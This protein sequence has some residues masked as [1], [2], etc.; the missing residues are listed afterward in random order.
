MRVQVSLPGPRDVGTPE[1]R[2]ARQAFLDKGIPR[3]EETHGDQL[4]ALAAKMRTGS[5]GM[6]VQFSGGY[7][8]DIP[9]PLMKQL[10]DKT[11]GSHASE[12]LARSMDAPTAPQKPKPVDRT[13]APAKAHELDDVAL[14]TTT[15]LVMVGANPEKGV[16]H[17]EAP[18]QG[19]VMKGSPHATATGSSYVAKHTTCGYVASYCASQLFRVL[20]ENP[21]ASLET[22]DK[23]VKGG[24]PAAYA[25]AATKHTGDL[26][27]YGGGND[28][29]EGQ[30]ALDDI[31]NVITKSD[32]KAAPMLLLSDGNLERNS[33]A[34]IRVVSA[35]GEARAHWRVP[36]ESVQEAMTAVQSG[37][38]PFALFVMLDKMPD[39]AHYVTVAVR[40]GSDGKLETIVLDSLNTQNDQW[41]LKG[42]R[43]ETTVQWLHSHLRPAVALPAQ[44]TLG[45]E[46]FDT[47]APDNVPLLWADGVVFAPKALRDEFGTLSR[48]RESGSFPSLPSVEPPVPVEMMRLVTE[49]CAANPQAKLFAL[50]TALLGGEA[51]MK[52][53]HGKFFSDVDLTA[54]AGEIKR[55]ASLIAAAR[56]A[57][58]VEPDAVGEAGACDG[59]LVIEAFSK[60]DGV[61]DAHAFVDFM[62]RG[63]LVKIFSAS[64]PS[65]DYAAARELMTALKPPLPSNVGPLIAAAKSMASGLEME[66]AQLR[67][68]AD[69]A[70]TKSGP[71]AARQ[72]KQK[73][74][75]AAE[76]EETLTA[77]RGRADELDR[78]PKTGPA[79]VALREPLLALQIAAAVQNASMQRA[80]LQE[81]VGTFGTRPEREELKDLME[82]LVYRGAT[83]EGLIH[84]VTSD[85]AAAARRLELA[86]AASWQQI[87]ARLETL[88]RGRPSDA[89]AAMFP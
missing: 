89:I 12:H 50:A 48:N 65:V 70:A 27:G 36:F 17:L 46:D 34:E 73:R 59:D 33:G 76:K 53:M 25:R 11:I 80:I 45:Q 68:E 18:H 2:L 84:L 29:V 3:P 77:L 31:R 82:V 14:S 26:S 88:T 24:D 71:M 41:L 56:S 32:P 83:L 23:A 37:R 1:D 16:Y 51:A 63:T 81:F 13:P 78:M 58:I 6:S 52:A 15:P 61:V 75:A 20:S 66:V 69:A 67:T 42:G 40:M 9:E 72:A 55:L 43:P 28:P 57:P 47:S 7:Y 39:S 21:K 19:T 87:F 8:V 74:A 62:V 30:L 79:S 38:Q 22:I 86:P 10:V 49:H 85:R 54:S 64:M 4:E 35:Q 60:R 5:N 44:C